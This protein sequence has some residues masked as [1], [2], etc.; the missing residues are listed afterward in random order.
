MVADSELRSR[1]ISSLRMLGNADIMQALA[2]RGVLYVEGCTDMDILRSWA[3]RLQ[4]RALALLTT[5]PMRKPLVFQTARGSPGIRARHFDVLQLVCESLPG[6]ELR[7]GDAHPA[8]PDTKLAGTG[9]QRRRGRRYEI[10]SH[11]LHPAALRRSDGGR[12]CPAERTRNMLAYWRDEFPPAAVR[13]PRAD[14][15]FLNVAKARTERLPPLLDAAGLQ[16]LPCTRYHEIADAM[17]AEEIHPEAVEK[18]DGIC[19][20]FGIEP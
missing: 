14:H 9:L 20:A 6:L 5:E 1:L 3:A 7:D 18:L 11:L 4:H 19:R 2:V 8:I 13:K 12:Q 17:L 16:G 10:E 15:P